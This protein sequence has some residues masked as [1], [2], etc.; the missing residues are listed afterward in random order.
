[1]ASYR[2]TSTGWKAT[3]SKRINGKLR[4]TSKRGFRTKTEAVMWAAA[5]EADI[6]GVEKQKK[7]ILFVDYFDNWVATYKEQKVQSSTLR[8]YRHASKVLHHYFPTTSIKEMRRSDYQRFINDYGATHAKETVQIITIAVRACVKSAIYDDYLTKDFTTNVELVYNHQKAQQVD[9]LSVDEI[10]RL[11]AITTEKLDRRYTGRYM[12]LTALYTGMRLG[13]IAALTWKDIDFLHQTISVTK[14]WSYVDKDFKQTKTKSSV[15]TIKV[16]AEFLSTL[17]ELKK[18]KTS[19]IFLNNQ[20][21]IPSSTA[22]NKLL[23]RLL[24]G[25]NINRP[26]YH[27]HSIRHSHVAYL[28]YQGID[29]YA[30]SKRLGHSNMTITA[31]RYAYLIDEYKEKQEQKITQAIGQLSGQHFGDL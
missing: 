4:Q 29:L 1:M 3:V 25:A 23:A 11:I 18:N 13:E 14:S 12:I 9:Y 8:K 10:N 21:H 17:S 28:L 26:G 15:R 30:I 7:N 2:K 31:K 27:F 5:I 16:P 20:N 6:D 24:S 19:M 22:V